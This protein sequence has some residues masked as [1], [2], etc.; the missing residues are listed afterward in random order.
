MIVCITTLLLLQMD[1]ET[2]SGDTCPR[3]AVP[4]AQVGPSGV[5]LM[6]RRPNSEPVT[7]CPPLPIRRVLPGQ[8]PPACLERGRARTYRMMTCWDGPRYA[9][10]N[11]YDSRLRSF[12]K[13]SWPHPKHN[14]GSLAAAGYSILVRTY[15]F[16]CSTTR[17]STP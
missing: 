13:R 10:F 9:A 2:Q 15:A 3:Y 8:L 17:I 4:R 1:R 16:R 5:R 6:E 7:P 14:P 12:G 11:S